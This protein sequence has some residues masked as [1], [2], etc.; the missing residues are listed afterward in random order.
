MSVPA[1]SPSTL[2]AL[3]PGSTLEDRLDILQRMARVGLWEMRVSDRRLFVSGEIRALFGIR[4]D[5][6]DPDFAT[7]FACVHPDDRDQ[8]ETDV[9]N[10]LQHGTPLDIE[11]RVLRAGGAV[12]HVHA[13]GEL[14]RVK[15]GEPAYYGTVQ[16]VTEWRL[17]EQASASLARRLC[18]TLESITDVFYTVDRDWRFT[19]LNGEAERLF[20]HARADLLGKVIWEAL[21]Y[22]KAQPGHGELQRA[23]RERCTVAFEDYHALHDMH[24]EVRAYPSDTGL[25]VYVHDNTLQKH[26]EAALRHSEERF[27]IIA[28]VT[29]DAIWDLDV[30]ND[31]LWFSATL[32]DLFGYSP[33]EFEASLALWIDRVHPDDRQRIDD[34]FNAAVHRSND[35]QWTDDYRFIRKDGSIAHVHDRARILRDSAGRALRVVGAVVDVSQ[36]HASDLRIHEQAALLDKAKDAIVV[37]GLDQRILYWNQGAQRLYGWDAGQALGLDVGVFLYPN[38][39]ALAKAVGALLATGEW[40]GEMT[41]RRQDGST[42]PVEAHWTLM[43]DERGMA[44]SIFAI[45]TDITERKEAERHVRYLAFHDALTHLPNRH[46]LTEHLEAA[47]GA[48]RDSASFNALLLIDLDNF[49][50]LNETLGHAVGDLLLQDMALRLAA[51]LPHDVTVARFGGDEFAVLLDNLDADRQRACAHAKHEGER[52][53]RLLSQPFQLDG[54]RLQ[55]GASIGVTVFS[56]DAVDAGE[57]LKRADLAMYRA[58]AAGRGTVRFFSPALQ[59]AASARMVLESDLRQGLR[60]HAFFL[61]YQPQV[62]R[63]GRIAGAEALVRWRHP[64]R[65]MVSPADFIPVAEEIGLALPLGHWVLEHACRQ[66]AAWAEQPATAH[67]EIAVNVSARQLHHPAFVAQ[68]LDCLAPSG[69]DPRRLKLEIT[70]GTLLDDVEDAIAKIKALKAYGMTFAIDDFGTGYSSL[71]Y[72]KRLPLDMLK[73][74]RSFVLDLTTNPNDA[75]IARTIIALGASLGLKVLAEGVETEAQRDFL[76][77]NGCQAYQGYL[78]AR[79]LAAEELALMLH[80]H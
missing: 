26:T 74:D 73:I 69:A 80:R 22:L 33:D 45:N 36:R 7:L 20:Q 76:F 24:S 15:E 62:E 55:L 46:L 77:E 12:R 3:E 61:H 63:N 56:S 47:L 4:G 49:K 67:L 64:T 57:L 21:P 28:R 75:V 65:G 13:R 27:R 53:V 39:D 8:V 1:S 66:L 68:V 40:S 32:H 78:C 50:T 42:L 60:D 16:D 48:S 29:S 44:R 41:G 14:A 51:N 18:T 54:C 34:G 10:A 38:A 25:A 52:I 17:A 59:A 35:E 6:P 70:E 5:A 71:A 2:R 58:K 37:I 79:P 30:P 72:L 9:A 31:T 11:H 43:R 19:Y 23:M